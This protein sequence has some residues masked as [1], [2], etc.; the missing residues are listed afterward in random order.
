MK[1]NQK[2][3]ANLSPAMLVL[4]LLTAISL[5]TT[6]VFHTVM[7]NRQLQVIRETEK[8]ELR[9][10]EKERDITDIEIRISQLDNRYEIKETLFP[11]NPNVPPKTALVRFPMES[12]VDINEG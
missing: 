10:K 6:G 8:V 3:K 5:G 7:K 11:S 4:L 12:I 2:K 9:V 1:K